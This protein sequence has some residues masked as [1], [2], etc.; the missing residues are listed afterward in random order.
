MAKK[1]TTNA[2]VAPA[3]KGAVARSAAPAP[4][5][6]PAAAPV[7]TPVRNS[8]IPKVSPAAA[9]KREIT[10]EQIAVRAYEIYRSGTGGSAEDNW[11][12]AERELR[13]GL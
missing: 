4:S 13:A 9:A 8:A 3:P 2:A 12:R 6:A 5:A 11:H 7:S 1:A 10:R